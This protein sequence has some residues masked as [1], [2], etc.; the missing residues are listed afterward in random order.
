MKKFLGA[1]LVVTLMVSFVVG[2]M[3]SEAGAYIKVEKKSDRVGD[4][5]GLP[6]SCYE[7]R[8]DPFWVQIC[9]SDPNGDL[10]CAVFFDPIPPT[11]P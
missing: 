9:C 6:P 2:V 3:S 8:I 4:G 7:T 5:G 1:A 11:L 10:H